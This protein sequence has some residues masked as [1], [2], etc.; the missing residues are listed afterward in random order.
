[1]GSITQCARLLKPGGLLV[2][3]WPNGAMQLRE[4]RLKKKPDAVTDTLPAS[5]AEPIHSQDSVFSPSRSADSKRPWSGRHKVFSR[6]SPVPVSLH[7]VSLATRGPDGERLDATD[8][9]RLEPGWR[10]PQ[11]CVHSFFRASL[12]VE[13]NA[14][15][16]D[17]IAETYVEKFLAVWQDSKPPSPARVR[18]VFFVGLALICGVTALIGAV[19]TRMYGHDVFITLENGWRVMNGQRPHLDFMSSWGVLWS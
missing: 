16:A 14:M 12:M 15:P 7:A 6:E 9:S 3:K 18:I 11:E 5:D 17:S 1:M 19:P 10:R 4:G 8:G 13:F 2:V